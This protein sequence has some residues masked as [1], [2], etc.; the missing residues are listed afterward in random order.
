MKEVTSGRVYLTRRACRSGRQ[1]IFI[2]EDGVFDQLRVME[3]LLSLR[4]RSTPL[5]RCIRCN[6]PLVDASRD[7]VKR[8]V[9][10]Y[11]FLAHDTFRRCPS[12]GRIYW[13]GTHVNRME[14]RITELFG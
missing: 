9:P 8:E 14:E 3:S 11:V 12:C 2:G 5:S 7:E 13:P 1:V 10:E 4:G 6:A